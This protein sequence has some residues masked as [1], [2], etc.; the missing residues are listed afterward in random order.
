M[1]IILFCILLSTCKD[2]LDR[3]KTIATVA[4]K[5]IPVAARP[6]N[7]NQPIFYT[8][9]PILSLQ[10]FSA[11]CFIEFL[12][13][14]LFCEWISHGLKIRVGYL[15]QHT[16]HEWWE[17]YFSFLMYFRDVVGGPFPIFPSRWFWCVVFKATYFWTYTLIEYLTLLESKIYHDLSSYRRWWPKI[18]RFWAFRS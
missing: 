13:N 17:K 5:I 14:V 1:F 12:R 7:V 3:M 2:C 11:H 18:L 6:K 8:T 16:I 4:P 15:R 9:T 10:S